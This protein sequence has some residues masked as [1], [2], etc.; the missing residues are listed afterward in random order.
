MTFLCDE[1]QNQF[2]MKHVQLLSTLFLILV[3]TTFNSRTQTTNSGTVSG[4]V[5]D[6][7]SG[8]ELIG[9]TILVKELN[10]GVVTNAYGF[11]SLTIPLQKV[12]IRFSYIGY[13]PENIEVEITSGKRLDVEL[14]PKNT[15]LEEVVVKLEKGDHN[16]RSSEIGIEKID[17]TG[18]KLIPVIFGEQDVLK[19]IQLLP[20][21]ATAG[22]GSTGFHVRGGSSDQ[23]LVLLDEAPV[24]NTSHLLGFF[25]VFNSD[26]I[27]NAELNKG[28]MQ[29]NYGGRASSVFDI[30]MKEGNMKE[31]DVSGGIGL[32]SSRLTVEGPIIQDRSSFIVSGRRTYAD[33]FLAFSGDGGMKNTSLYF[34]DLNV[35]TNYIVNEKNRVYLSGY[36]GRDYFLFDDRFGFNWGNATT[37]LRWNHL[38]NDKLFLN[39][40]LIYSDYDYEVGLEMSDFRID[41]Q[42]SIVDVNWKEDFQFYLNPQNTLKF[43]FNLIYHKFYPGEATSTNDEFSTEKIIDEKNALEHGFYALND[44][45]IS[46]RIKINYG[47]RLSGFQTI[48]PGT[49][50]SF[51]QF[52]EIVDSSHYDSW[53]KIKR[54]NFNLEPRIS[55]S[56]VLTPTSSIKAGYA[57]NYQYLHMLSNSTSSS[58]T[59]LWISS[60]TNVEPQ[61]IDHI[62]LGYF[63]NFKNNRLKTSVEFYYKDMQNLIDY[64]NGAE[65]TMN[66][67]VESELVFGKGRAYGMELKIEKTSGKLTGWLGYTLAR[68]ERSFDDIQDSWYP[69]KYDRMHDISIV[70]SYKLSD[71]LILSG[72]WIYYTGNAVTYPTGKY[73]VEDFIINLYSER[74]Q[75]RMPDYH[76]LDLGLTWQ[77]KKTDKFESS[78]NFSIYNA[79][80]RKNAYSISFRQN[81]DNPQYTEAVKMSL[82]SIVP[83]VTYNF[84]F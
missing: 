5:R 15:E 67:L 6:A 34:Y 77:R 51:D 19:S 73:K 83:S 42:S 84:K 80:A 39:S 69:A 49:E 25:S 2:I 11:Y 40:S 61:I 54:Y 37:T 62:S 79:Y 17:I 82:F 31:Y 26:A 27:K 55:A 13:S 53:E 57:R 60:S 14:H 3:F 64:K 56:C 52:G 74:N 72:T 47:I 1:N 70:A 46:K 81:A 75:E 24:Y 63:R 78:W 10:K 20:G 4:Y 32:I 58:P 48:G 36:F 7:E 9:A 66:E 71:K 65:I 41:I 76:R 8:E 35:K 22:E 30:Q 59:D 18:I 23:N 29:A 16:I 43:G 33:M 50:Y 12:I 28:I 68:T 44:H 38:F 45:Q 21:V